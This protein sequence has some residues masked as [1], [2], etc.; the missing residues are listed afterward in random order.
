MTAACQLCGLLI[1]GR[2]SPRPIGRDETAADLQDFD[3][4]AGAMLVHIGQYHMKEAG[5]ELMAVANLASKVY[6]MTLA[7]SS[8]PNFHVLGKAWRTAIVTQLAKDPATHAGDPAAPGS[9]AGPSSTESESK[10]KNSERNAS[11]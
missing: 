5:S 6:V 11:T 10:E 7:E 1:A 4:L 8:A 2:V 9:T 3:L